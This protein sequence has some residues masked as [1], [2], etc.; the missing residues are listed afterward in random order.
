[1]YDPRSAGPAED[2][3][4]GAD[5]R[6][7]HRHDAA[8][9]AP[10]PEPR[11]DPPP[12]EDGAPTDRIVG[13]GADARLLGAERAVIDERKLVDYA[14]NPDHPTGGAKARVFLAA[15]GV[16]RADAPAVAAQL[17]AGVTA[18]PPVRGRADAYGERFTVDIPVTGPGG[19]AVVRT[20]WIYDPGA[21]VPRLVTVFVR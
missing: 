4:D 12:D 18:A 19:T 17:R 5:R 1:V 7:A 3:T 20:G 14:L 10:D 8:P 13:H 21:T 15:L 16:D 2:Q 11:P 6:D 9:R